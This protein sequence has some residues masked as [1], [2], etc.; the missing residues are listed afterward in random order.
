MRPLKS[1]AT[2]AVLSALLAGGLAVATP[3][4]ASAAS[5]TGGAEAKI[6]IGAICARLADYI[7]FLEGRPS[8]RLRDF[9]LEQA[10]NLYSEY[11]K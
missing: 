2:A 4:T 10:R 6:T 7:A 1:I 3:V 8:S 9:L 5:Q 11:C